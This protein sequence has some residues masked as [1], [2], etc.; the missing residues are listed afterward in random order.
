MLLPELH[1]KLHRWWSSLLLMSRVRQRMIKMS[2]GTEST[3]LTLTKSRKRV[4]GGGEQNN[5]GPRISGLDYS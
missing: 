5:I 4:L 1:S 2:S 3:S